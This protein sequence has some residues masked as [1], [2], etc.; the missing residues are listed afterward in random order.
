M[1]K[2]GYVLYNTELEKYFWIYHDEP[3]WT[4]TPIGVFDISHLETP[5]GMFTLIGHVQST[6]NYLLV[7]CKM[8]TKEKEIDKFGGCMM[9]MYPQVDFLHPISLLALADEVIMEVH[10]QENCRNL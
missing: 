6:H 8:V 7:Y 1:F 9:T 2:S 3:I 5:G 10:S 4:D